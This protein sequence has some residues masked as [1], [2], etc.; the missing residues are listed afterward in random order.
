VNASTGFKRI[1]AEDRVVSREW[2]FDVFVCFLDVG[3][4]FCQ[5][6]VDDTHEFQVDKGLVERCISCSFSDT[7][8]GTVDDICASFNRCDVVGY[9]ETSVLVTVPVD[10]DFTAFVTAVFDDFFIDEMEEFLDTV[11]RARMCRKRTSVVRPIPLLE[12][13]FA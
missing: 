7:Q 3:I 1:L 6:I 11:W 10:F 13:K 4:E 2:N 5:I 12:G 8:G 9:A